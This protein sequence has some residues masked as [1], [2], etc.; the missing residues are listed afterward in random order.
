MSYIRRV[1]IIL[2]IFQRKEHFIVND[3]VFT[4]TKEVSLEI[5][6]LS[7][8]TRI[9]TSNDIC[10]VQGMATKYILGLYKNICS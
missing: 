7:T 3:Y 10:T 4:E 1:C 6:L 9:Y 5:D 2:D 8:K